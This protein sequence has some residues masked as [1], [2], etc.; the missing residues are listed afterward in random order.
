MNS[1]A[2]R[3]RLQ[4]LHRRRLSRRPLQHSLVAV[5]R[6]DGSFRWAEARGDA[7]PAGQSMRPETPYFIA[8]IDKLLNATVAMRLAE[9]GHLA[10]EAPVAAYLSD[11]HIRGLHRLGGSDYSERLTVRHLLSHTSGL[12]DWLEDRAAGHPSF[13]DGV[14]ADGDRA[15]TLDEI[16]AIVRE[17]RPHFPP[18]DLSARHPKIR[19]S[20]T[21]FIL[22]IAIIEAVTGEQI[23]RVQERMLFHPLDMTQTWLAGR[24]EPAVPAPLPAALHYQG[25]P[26]EIPLLLH[27]F[28]GI[29]STVADLV[30]FLRGLVQGRIFSD[31]GTFPLMRRW[32]RF[33]VPLDTAAL[34]QP[35]W[36]IDYGF[37]LMRYR[38]PRVFTRLKPLPA[39]IGHSGST[40]TWLFYC[41]EWDLLL[42]GTVD[43]V[44]AGAVPYRMMPEI[45]S[46]VG[47]PE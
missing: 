32:N 46:A 9:Q 39:V 16:V 10:I 29:Y 42:A 20:D 17:L 12:P 44:T 14:I 33:G 3:E 36:P 6:G 23:S 34:R 38:L 25:R 5:E 21:N 11:A 26:L 15:V 41:P 22:L 1:R 4:D 2:V 31:P 47:P 13:V 43:E 37:G 8:S 45:L 7:Q 18:Q 28:W 30:A 27:S 35:G 24:S 19:Y 40:G